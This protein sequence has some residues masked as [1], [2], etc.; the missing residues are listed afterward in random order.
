MK[1]RISHNAASVRIGVEPPGVIY[2]LDA[3]AFSV[4]DAVRLPLYL[5]PV[6]AGTPTMA[7]DYVERRLDISKYLVRN[8]SATFLVRATGNSMTGAGIHA[9]DLLVVDRS[10]EPRDGRIVIAAVDGDLTV[11]RLRIAGDDIWLQPENPAY[12]GI[13]CRADDDLPILGVVVSVI[14]EV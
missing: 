5:T 2:A 14:H 10:I 1:R 3:I 6:S 8:P 13:R 12:S 4:I 9:G 11:K 7:A